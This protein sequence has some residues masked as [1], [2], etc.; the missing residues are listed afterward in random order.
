[1]QLQMTPVQPRILPGGISNGNQVALE[2]VTPLR[3][4]H[5][6]THG[7]AVHVLHARVE[8]YTSGHINKEVPVHLFIIIIIIIIIIINLSW[9]WRGVLLKK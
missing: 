1:M 4:R 7:T 5:L 9:N 2:A 8:Q 3:C 6:S